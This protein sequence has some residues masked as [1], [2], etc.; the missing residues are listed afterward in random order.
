M[1]YWLAVIHEP[2]WCLNRKRCVAL[3]QTGEGLDFLLISKPMAKAKPRG[4][5]ARPKAASE[6]QVVEAND[7]TSVPKR[8]RRRPTDNA[9]P[10]ASSAVPRQSAVW[11]F[12]FSYHGFATVV[13]AAVWL[14]EIH[15][16]LDWWTYVPIAF[17]NCLAYIDSSGREGQVSFKL[18]FVIQLAVNG[19]VAIG[20]QLYSLLTAALH[21][22]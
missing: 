13:F 5:P 4:D 20:L 18:Y 10:I 16:R 3:V 19:T 17:L 1:V 21:S 11:R 2:G 12:L 8:L 22:Q 7:R 9:S 15:K 14:V 6:S